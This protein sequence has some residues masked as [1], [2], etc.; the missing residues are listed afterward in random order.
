MSCDNFEGEEP[1][2]WQDAQFECYN[3]RSIHSLRCV[4]ISGQG[5]S[6]AF[7]DT[8][9]ALGSDKRSAFLSSNALT[10]RGE[11]P[12]FFDHCNFFVAEFLHQK[13]SVEALRPLP[14]QVFCPLRIIVKYW[15]HSSRS[16]REA[17][18]KFVHISG[19]CKCEI[20]TED[21]RLEIGKLRLK[22]P[23]PIDMIY[24]LSIL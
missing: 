2:N 20:W 5:K 1:R 13:R 12:N 8:F 14:Q 23:T 15:N 19:Q 16:F 21:E 17:C 9:S 11:I 22:A 24:S 18:L 4:M 6:P 3:V 7:M 10:G